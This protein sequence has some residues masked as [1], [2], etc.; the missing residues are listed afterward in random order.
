MKSLMAL[1]LLVPT[2]ALAD[3]KGMEYLGK[4]DKMMNN[5][6]DGVFESKLRVKTPDGSSRE[7]GFTTYQ[8]VPDKRLVRFTA[9][10]DVKGMGVLVENKDTM[11]VFLP[12]FQRVRRMGTHV[13]NQTFMGSDFSYEDMSQTSFTP[14]YEAKI[15]AEDEKSVTLD[16]L[17]KPGMDTEFPHMKMVVDKTMSAPTKMEYFDAGGKRLK[18]QLRDGYH[19]DEGRDY[20][21]PARVVVIDHRRNDHTS[22]ILFTSFKL[23]SGLNDDLFSQRSLIRGQ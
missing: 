11:Y 17:Q 13:K 2:V 1:T 5:F 10:G 6:S 9:P 16:L 3:P 8:K 22:E 21:G 23:N 14:Y 4:V 20:Y 18:T 19:K 7:Y 15:E 12:G